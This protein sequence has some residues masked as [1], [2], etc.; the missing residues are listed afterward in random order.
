MPDQSA[1]SAERHV[2][3][4]IHST[5]TKW[6][7]APFVLGV[8]LVS[9]AEIVASHSG[10][11]A[12]R[13]AAGWTSSLGVALSAISLVLVLVSWFKRGPTK[14]G[15]FREERLPSRYSIVA[16]SAVATALLAFGFIVWYT[17]SRGLTTIH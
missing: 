7:A 11:S 4:T 14:H 9:A 17:L 3:R 8:A 16:W 12:S 6:F 13:A 15:G 1:E 2:V 10:D 5:L